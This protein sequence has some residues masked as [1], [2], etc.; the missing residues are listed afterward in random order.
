MVALSKEVNYSRWQPTPLSMDGMEIQAPRPPGAAGRPEAQ[1][2]CESCELQ[3]GL[4]ATYHFWG[5]TGGVV[6]PVTV[7]WS[8]NRYELGLFR[9]AT[10]QLLKDHNYHEPRVL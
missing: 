10:T 7:N 9:V 6:L 1:A 3:A 4:G 2:I 5:P 8:D